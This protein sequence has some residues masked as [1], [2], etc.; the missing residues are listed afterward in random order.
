[1]AQRL[2][3]YGGG[4]TDLFLITY[5]NPDGEG[6]GEGGATRTAIAPCSAIGLERGYD[7]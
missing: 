6:N 5:A 4:S 7:W 2:I 1:M 3:S